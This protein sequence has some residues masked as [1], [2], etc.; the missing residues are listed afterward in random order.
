MQM[1]VML[2]RRAALITTESM[3]KATAV[4]LPRL[5]VTENT[6]EVKGKF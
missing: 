5:S 3:L 2:V 1:V 6:T 4:R